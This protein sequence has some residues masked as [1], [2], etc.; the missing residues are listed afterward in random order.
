MDSVGAADDIGAD[1]MLIDGALIDGAMVPVKST[2][3]TSRDDGN[4]G[5]NTKAPGGSAAERDPP[6]MKARV[7]AGEFG[8]EGELVRFALIEYF[9]NRPRSGI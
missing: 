5:S 2:P 7:E 3:F 6:E 4:K 9:A 1:P 8:S